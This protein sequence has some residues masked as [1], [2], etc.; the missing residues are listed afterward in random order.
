MASIKVFTCCAEAFVGHLDNIWLYSQSSHNYSTLV[1][2]ADYYFINCLIILK[3]EISGR[4]GRVMT[5]GNC[6]IHSLPTSAQL[7][8]LCSGIHKSLLMLVPS[9]IPLAVVSSYM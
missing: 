1:L 2:T 6:P 3:L 9:Q 8:L 4:V 5:S 7:S